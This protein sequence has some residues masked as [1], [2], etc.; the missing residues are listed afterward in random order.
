MSCMIIVPKSVHQLHSFCLF[1]FHFRRKSIVLGQR[2]NNFANLENK[3]SHP[4]NYFSIYI[5]FPTKQTGCFAVGQHLPV[6]LS[7]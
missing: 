2:G 7:L 4:K 3:T 5:F 6:L 1:A